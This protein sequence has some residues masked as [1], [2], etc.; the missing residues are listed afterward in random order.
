MVLKHKISKIQLHC[1][2]TQNLDLKVLAELHN[3]DDL[4][5]IPSLWHQ[6]RPQNVVIN[7]KQTQRGLHRQCLK[8]SKSKLVQT[9]ARIVALIQDNLQFIEKP[10]TSLARKIS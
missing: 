3:W 2:I 4:G 5:P 1:Q 6:S 10:A 9:Q 7:I 8:K